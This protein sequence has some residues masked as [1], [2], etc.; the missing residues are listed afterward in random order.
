MSWMRQLS[1][2]RVRGQR[3]VAKT[4]KQIREIPRPEP[5]FYQIQYDDST[6]DIDKGPI[7]LVKENEPIQF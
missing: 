4:P 1:I 2:T 7:N 3:M 6:A 5:R